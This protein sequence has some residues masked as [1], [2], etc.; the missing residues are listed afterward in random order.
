VNRR[1]WVNAVLIV[2]G[3]LCVVLGVLGIFLPLLPTTPFLL[4]AAAC[5]MRSSPKFYAWLVEHPKLG[6]Y[7]IYY[8]NGQGIPKRAKIMAILM[9]WFTMGISV[10]WVVPVLWVKLLLLLVGVSV[11]IYLWRQPTF[12]PNN[13]D[14]TP[15]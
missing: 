3:W 9:I 7:I 13:D 2:F 4:L 5:F 15:S 6:K 11:S 12:E 10:I 1:K 8:L 14:I